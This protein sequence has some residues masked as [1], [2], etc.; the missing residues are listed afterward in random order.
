MAFI[1]KSHFGGP[2]P[3][4]NAAVTVDGGLRAY[5]LRVYNWMT[6]GLV[7]TGLV[8]YMVAET[9]LRS[10]FFMTGILPNGTFAV[11]PTGLGMLTIFAPLV[12]VMVLSFGVNRLSKEV[13]QMLFWAFCAVM[14]ASLANILL[15]Y[16]HVSVARTFFVTAATFGAMSLWGYTT[17][18]DLSSMGSFLF[19]G[20][21]GIVIAS[22][23]NLFLHS[24]A[25]GFVVSLVG[26]VL[27][28]LLVA[29][30]TQRIKATYQYNVAYFG[31]DEIQK[32]SVYDALSLYLN[33]INLFTFLLQFMG[34]RNSNQN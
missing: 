23:V 18:R 8:A 29:F 12:F 26:V 21:I 2:A 31:P 17:R 4:A 33:F 19:M 24:A 1:P 7:V 6:I 9:S 25:L 22:L 30:D 32:R 5:L 16:T 11:R 27:F 20:L 13:A 28:T 34:V 14:G 15:I 3:S 10:Y